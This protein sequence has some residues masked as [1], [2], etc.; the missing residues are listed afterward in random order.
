MPEATFEARFEPGGNPA[1]SSPPNQ[2]LTLLLGDF[3][4]W[5]PSRRRLAPIERLLNPAPRGASFPSAWPLFALD[6]IWHGSALRLE[7]LEVVR[8]ASTRAASDHLPVRAQFQLE[9]GL[10]HR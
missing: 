7:R 6:R 5:R 3:N 4:E 1:A 9:Q 8:T 2:A 10:P